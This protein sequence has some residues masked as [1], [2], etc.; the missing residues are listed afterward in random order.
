M[1]LLST[2]NLA[3]S[4]ASLLMLAVTVVLFVD[5]VV[6]KGTYLAKRIEDFLW[7][8]ILVLTVGSV[9]MSLVY[10]EYFG[11]IPCSLCWLQ[12][13]AIYPQALM[14]IIA[15][16][17]G[18]I[19]FA[20]IYGIGMSLFGFGVAVYQYIYQM[21]PKPTHDG[22]PL[23][24]LLDGSNAD[25][26]V[27]VIDMFGFVTFPFVSAVTFALLIVLYLYLLRSAKAK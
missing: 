4:V 17:L 1:D 27:K 19:K 16:R 24:C 15:Y 7:P 5:Y 2:L 3:I 21:M 26:A 22:P 20:P 18:D 23:P 14:T 8:L 9:A 6:Y 13:I 10:S 12:R 11:F 25:C